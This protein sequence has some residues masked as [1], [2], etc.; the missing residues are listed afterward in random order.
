MKYSCPVCGFNGLRRP[1]ANY[2]ICPCCSTE[3]GASDFSWSHD[4]LR[5]QWIAL[6]SSWSNRYI[7]E[8]P[9]WSAV[10]QLRDAQL[11]LSDEDLTALARGPLVPIGR[12][13][14]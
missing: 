9:N 5:S 7:P 13:I 4:E 6:G 3:F 2:T 14:V 11:A 10:R 1:P 12:N 8:P